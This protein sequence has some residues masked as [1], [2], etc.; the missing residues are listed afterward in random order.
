M[1]TNTAT[2]ETLTAEVRV[3]MVGSRQIT[4]SVAR[5]L[6]SYN[7]FDTYD[8]FDLDQFVPF[9]R[10]RAGI[11][12]SALVRCE[13]GAKGAE[14]YPTKNSI[15]CSSPCGH[16]RTMFN[17]RVTCGTYERMEMREYD[18]T[19][20]G[21]YALTGELVTFSIHCDDPRTAVTVVR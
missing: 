2:V 3:L 14:W 6:D 9:G 18:F 16:D 21:R 8:H 1:S 15:T 12:G 10:I 11:K 5:Q 13:K 20:V 4:L 7:I 19:W 17:G